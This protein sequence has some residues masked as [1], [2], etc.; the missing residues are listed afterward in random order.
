V[1]SG[2]GGLSLVA[3]VEQNPDGTVKILRGFQR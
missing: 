1:R 2:E 3:V